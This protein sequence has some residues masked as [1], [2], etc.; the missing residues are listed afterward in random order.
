MGAWDTEARLVPGA[1]GRPLAAMASSCSEERDKLLACLVDSECIKSGRSIKECQD[2]P[3]AGNPS[4][5]YER[6]MAF[7]LCRRGQLDMRKRFKGN[8]PIGDVPPV[9]LEERDGGR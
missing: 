8:R 2:L 9:D 5:C 6:R 7:Y 1:R 4:G 3:E